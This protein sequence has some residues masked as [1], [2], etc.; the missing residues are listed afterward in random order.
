M[1]LYD[2]RTVLVVRVQNYIDQKLVTLLFTVGWYAV[3]LYDRQEVTAIYP[4]FCFRSHL[5]TLYLPYLLRELHL[6]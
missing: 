6:F 2:Q 4:S 1:M 5:Y 3:T